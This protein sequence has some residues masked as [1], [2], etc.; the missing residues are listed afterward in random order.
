VPRLAVHLTPP[1]ALTTS[2][3]LLILRGDGNE[4]GNK[5]QKPTENLKKIGMEEETRGES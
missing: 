2:S 4:G 3:P 5:R 1:P